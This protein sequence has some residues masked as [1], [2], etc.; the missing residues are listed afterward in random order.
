MSAVYLL[1]SNDVP[2]SSVE[3]AGE[4]MTQISQDVAFSTPLN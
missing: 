1:N 2:G 4:R 3:P